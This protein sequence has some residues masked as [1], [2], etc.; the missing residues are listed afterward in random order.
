[1][2]LRKRLSS[3]PECFSFVF[4]PFEDKPKR[5]HR[6]ELDQKVVLPEL[7]EACRSAKAGG[8]IA[9][10]RRRCYV[11][12]KLLPSLVCCTVD[13][14][15]RKP[16][17]SLANTRRLRLALQ[18]LGPAFVKLGQA[19]ASREDVLSDV[20]V[21]EL[22]KLCDQ[23]APFPNEEARLLVATELG[24]D[25]P[26]VI[27][28]VVASASLGQVYRVC[29]NGQ[30]YAMK[31]QRPGLA[32]GLARD[33]VILK[34]MAKFVRRIVRWACATPI[35]PVDIVQSWA[36]TLWEELDYTLE[37]RSMDHMR[38]ALCGRISGLV[39]P[40][41]CS[42]MSSLRVLTTD[43]IDGTKVTQDPKCVK[44]KHIRTGVEAFAAMIL[45][46]GLVHADPHAGNF[47]ITHHGNHACLLDFGMCIRVP[48]AHRT[49]WAK[50]IVHLVNHD[51]DGV[52][53][54]LIDIGF[55]PQDCPRAEI[56]PVM[57]KIWDQLVDC[58]SDINKRK[59]AVQLLYSEIMTFVRRF[60]F[61][62]PDYYVALARAL[63]TLEGLALAADC[64][65]D[66]F[67]A[68]FPVA[69]RFLASSSFQEKCALGTGLVRSGTGAVCKK[70]S[71]SAMGMAIATAMLL[72]ALTIVNFA[73][74]K[75][76]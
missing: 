68:I 34:G 7:D 6:P 69:L 11:T 74:N 75:A 28:E 43:W 8:C 22:R 67:K 3:L 4:V 59:V 52:L 53:D 57:S 49:A 21:A 24:S 48:P 18:S 29:V 71:A 64:E 42:N 2:S 70:L 30:E 19:A 55:F 62:L 17:H 20:V 54:A 14:L 72:S 44:D 33:V 66:I 39:I 13:C 45:E 76:R 40:N 23:V 63:V 58:G 73:V 47:I 26:D 41:V 38:S 27:G 12:A 5:R 65:F 16:K 1:M 25:A 36:L 60:K 51:H 46:V 50:C 61:G 31:V 15:R 32:E 10:V 9:L 35:D 37:A 56:L